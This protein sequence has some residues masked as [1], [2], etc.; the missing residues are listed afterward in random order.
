MPIAVHQSL[1]T[2]QPQKPFRKKA[3]PTV[4]AGL[5]EVVYAT[6][7]AGKRA[8]ACGGGGPRRRTG[9]AMGRFFGGSSWWVWVVPW[10]LLVLGGGMEGVKGV[11]IPDCTYAARSNSC[12]R[13]TCYNVRTCGIRE[14]VDSYIH[15][16]PTAEYGLIQDWDTSLVTDM[17]YAFSPCTGSFSTYCDSSS[18][19]I[20]NFNANI[21]AWQVGAVTKMEGSTY[22]LFLGGSFPLLPL[23][24]ALTIF[25][26]NGLFFFNSFFVFVLFIFPMLLIIEVF[27]KAEAFNGD[28]STWDVGN[29]TTMNYS[30]YLFC[31]L[32]FV[33]H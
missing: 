4:D 6:R 33:P 10:L 21:S 27:N 28:I 1:T 31:L 17:S 32:P 11:P 25:L 8:A 16:G 22:T 7:P 20:S 12:W 15:G 2:I 3:C 9:C 18:I 26:N 29:V 5:P 30:T 14:A 23:V 24:L 19:D 13:E